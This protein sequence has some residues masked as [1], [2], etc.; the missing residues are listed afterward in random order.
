M[1]GVG[2]SARNAGRYQHIDFSLCLRLPLLVPLK[3]IADQL[4]DQLSFVG[5]P[6]NRLQDIKPLQGIGG[7]HDFKPFGA[8]AFFAVAEGSLSG[9]VAHGFP[10]KLSR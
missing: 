7:Q 6:E 8:C 4:L 5:A 1:Y 9:C 10:R 3:L 2:G